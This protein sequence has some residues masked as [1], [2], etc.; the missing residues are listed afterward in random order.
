M[1]FCALASLAPAIIFI[2]FV[3][4]WVDFTPLIFL[5]KILSDGILYFKLLFEFLYCKFQVAFKTVV[6]VL[7]LGYFLQ[8]IRV[9]PVHEAIEPGFKI[10]YPCYRQVIKK[11]V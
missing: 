5:L 10:F 11:S 8:V 3:I 6:D 9:R 7:F 1:F 4:C 2:A